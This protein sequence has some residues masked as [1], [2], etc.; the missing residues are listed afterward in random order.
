[1]TRL[2]GEELLDWLHLAARPSGVE[3]RR[4]LPGYT[5]NAGTWLRMFHDRV[6][7]EP[8]EIVFRSPHAVREQATAWLE[9]VCPRPT[10]W[11]AKLLN[12][13]IDTTDVLEDPPTALLHGDYWPG[14]VIVANERLGVI[15]AI[16]WAR[17]PIWLDIAYFLLHL[18]AVD[19]QV[20][21]QGIGWPADLVSRAE[22]QFLHGYFGD[23]T[24]D[25]R[26]LWLFKVLALL[27]KWARAEAVL[28]EAR[29]LR[30][31]GKHVTFPWKSRY[32]RTLL[33][34]YEADPAP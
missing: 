5:R 8:G 32:Y 23:Q 27:A 17:G 11:C 34:R 9:R 15:D 12:R 29:G 18:R 6:R 14:N 4:A 26:A 24:F 3:A 10:A 22:E 7:M 1:M 28:S 13:L 33:G 21:M 30:R 19:R 16:G 2:S 25:R 20:R 31:L